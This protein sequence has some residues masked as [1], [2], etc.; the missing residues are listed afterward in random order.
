M[1]LK[2]VGGSIKKS[3]VRSKKSGVREAIV[4]K[5]GGSGGPHMR[6]LRGVRSILGGLVRDHFLFFFGMGFDDEFCKTFC[7]FEI[8][9]VFCW[10]PRLFCGPAAFCGT[11]RGRGPLWGCRVEW[12][13]RAAGSQKIVGGC[14]KRDE[15]STKRAGGLELSCHRTP[16]KKTKMEV[17]F[18]RTTQKDHTGFNLSMLSDLQFQI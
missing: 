14:S 10:D 1:I 12:S 7:I 18:Y 3:G 11:E 6:Y 15:R 5:D 4:K 13:K 17:S 16:F 8:I 2:K 9:E